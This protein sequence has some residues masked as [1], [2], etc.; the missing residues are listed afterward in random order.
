[1]IRR[2]PY[3]SDTSDTLDTWFAA[4]IAVFQGSTDPADFPPL[5][6][7]DAQRIWLGG[8]AAAWAECP[9]GAGGLC[10]EEVD[11]ALALVLAGRD[12]LCEHLLRDHCPPDRLMH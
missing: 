9:P 7:A 6:D 5:D 3:S 10:D 8:F 12:T 1:M 2:S 11:V 4:G